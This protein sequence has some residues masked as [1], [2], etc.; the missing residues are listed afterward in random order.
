MAILTEQDVFQF[1]ASS[2]PIAELGGTVVPQFPYGV[3]L[4]LGARPLGLWSARRDSFVFRELA[5]YEPNREAADIM[6]VQAQSLALLNRCRNGWAEQF[7][8][9]APAKLVA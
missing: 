6:D 5:N 7:A 1:L 9:Q 2:G 8:Q 4:C 3:L